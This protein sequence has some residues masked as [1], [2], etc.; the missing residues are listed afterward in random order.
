MPTLHLG[1]MIDAVLLRAGDVVA[2]DCC[3]PPDVRLGRSS[4]ELLREVG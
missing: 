3:N 4:G 2:V 1:I